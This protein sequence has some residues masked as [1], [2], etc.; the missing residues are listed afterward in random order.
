[1]AGHQRLELGH[2]LAVPPG[3][4]IGLDPILERGGV[5]RLQRHDLGLGERLERDVGERWAAPLRERRTEAGR[6]AFGH[7]RRERAPALVAQRLEAIEV[8]LPRLDVQ[9]VALR[10]RDEPFGVGSE[11]AAQP[12]DRHL[13]RLDGSLGIM[14][15]PQVVDDPFLRHRGPAPQQEQREQ[16]ALA[17]AGDWQRRARRLAP[18][19]ARGLGNPRG[20]H[21]RAARRRQP[22]LTRVAV[23]EALAVRWLSIDR[24]AGVRVAGSGQSS[25]RQHL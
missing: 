17:R 19:P 12:R 18:R 1:M 24:D 16:G 22:H 14:L 7:A 9:P 15:A 20:K 5:Q 25:S 3:E 11:G 6:R 8:Q 4:E 21:R 2:Q 10:G 13:E 23:S